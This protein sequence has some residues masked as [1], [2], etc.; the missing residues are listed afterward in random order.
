LPLQRTTRILVVPEP[1][2]RHPEAECH[3]LMRGGDVPNHA[4]EKLLELV[5]AAA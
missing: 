2:R 1:P 5:N 3:H 4:C